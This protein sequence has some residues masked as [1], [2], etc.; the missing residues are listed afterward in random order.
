M[1]ISTI[2]KAGRSGRAVQ[3]SREAL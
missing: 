2:S 1:L 3:A